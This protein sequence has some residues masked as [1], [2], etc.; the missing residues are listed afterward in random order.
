[1]GAAKR[2]SVSHQKGA[3]SIREKEAL[4]RI[5]NDGVGALDPLHDLPSVRGQQKK[6]A[7]RGIHVEPELLPCAQ[8]CEGVEI[9]DRAGVRRPG[10]AGDEERA[11]SRGAVAG[12][13]VL[14]RVEADPEGSIGG[15]GSDAR[16][17]KAGEHGGLR[18]RV[19][20]LVRSV[21][22]PAEKVLG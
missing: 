6:S 19:M 17:R 12:D 7:V 2:F 20:R 9:V 5:E 21:E 8:V 10:I 3:C 4:V 14:E 11:E 16:L 22:G 1:M 18:D 13:R 15:E